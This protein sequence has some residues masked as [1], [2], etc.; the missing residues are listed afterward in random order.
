MNDKFALLKKIQY[1]DDKP[2]LG[3]YIL[4]G[5][6]V[7]EEPNIIKWGIWFGKGIR[8]IAQTTVKFPHRLWHFRWGM[9]RRFWVSTVFVGCNIVR[10]DKWALFETSVFEKGNIIYCCR[11]S[12]YDEAEAQHNYTVQHLSNF[13]ES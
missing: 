9:R 4:D 7:V 10:W 1:Y 2:I 8:R 3:N 5:R 11:C 6:T 13:V 12:T